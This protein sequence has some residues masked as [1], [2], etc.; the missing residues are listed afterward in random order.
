MRYA[1][2]G[3]Q[4]AT[5]IA[6]GAL[7]VTDPASSATR[8]F[9]TIVT[10]LRLEPTKGGVDYLW[11]KATVA[12]VPHQPPPDSATLL[13][14][15]ALEG[16]AGT[17]VTDARGVIAQFYL[18]PSPVDRGADAGMLEHRSLYA[19][20]LGKGMLSVLNVPFPDEPI[21]LGGR[22]QVERVAIRGTLSF[23]QL[24]T[25]TLV[26]RT[27]DLL[28]LSYRFGGAFDPGSGLVESE[29]KLEV[30][31]GG[32]CTVNLHRPLPVL[33][34]DEVRVHATLNPRD[35]A[36]GEQSTRVG[37]RIESK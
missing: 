1:L 24:T 30:S 25:F 11:L 21:G 13:I 20:E 16:S 17:M 9:P 22:W 34:E 15:G 14:F 7:S 35:G 31:G 37:T 8:A 18:R 32:N 29:L 33:Q 23:V 5:V 12:A 19:M 10:P 4:D 3:A 6:S 27:G 36:P 28:E 2:K 26:A